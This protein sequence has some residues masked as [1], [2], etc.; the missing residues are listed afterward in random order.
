MDAVICV[1]GDDAVDLRGEGV[2]DGAVGG[3]E[4]QDCGFGLAE[5]EGAGGGAVEVVDEWRRDGGRRC[6][7]RCVLAGGQQS[8]DGD[9]GDVVGPARGGD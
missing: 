9:R 4:D 6:W 1:V 5:V 2:G 7:G 8:E 3:E